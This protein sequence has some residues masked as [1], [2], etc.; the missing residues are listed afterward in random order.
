MKRRPT[1][2][3]GIPAFNEEANIT[4]LIRALLRQ[5]TPNF[6]LEKILVV[7]DHST[8]ATEQFV[9]SVR[10]RRVHLLVNKRRLGLNGTQNVILRHSKSDILI[11]FDADVLPKNDNC[12][13]LLIAP[14]I[15]NPKVGLTSGKLYSL[16]VMSNIISRILAN[17]HEM[18]RRVF[19]TLPNHHNLYLCAGRVRAMSRK[20]Y[21]QIHWPEDV[22]EDAYSY[23][24]AVTHKLRFVYQ[25]NAIVYFHPPTTIEDHIKQNNR[26]VTGKRSLGKYFPEELL[27]REYHLPLL[28][29]FKEMYIFFLKRPFS[30][31]AYFLLM[32]YIS[33]FK[34]LRQDNQ[35][36]YEIA[37]TSKNIKPEYEKA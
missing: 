37:Y 3:I 33:L 18:K 10:D 24:Q 14:L 20:L 15:S 19:E 21:S 13:S 25:P 2:T 23:L 6:R 35:S 31:P 27:R 26:F 29:V 30:I 11:L 7:S 36:R 17:A 32:L 1:V 8:D 5:K 22:P 28:S 12:I 34:N 9:R 16:R 4:H